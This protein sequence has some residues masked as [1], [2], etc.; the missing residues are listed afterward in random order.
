MF[1]KAKVKLMIVR[2]W[3]PTERIYCQD[4]RPELYRPVP[5]SAQLLASI[6]TALRTLT[7]PTITSAR[8][9]KRSELQ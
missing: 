6:S 7:F 2:V 9:L 4:G 1:T 5:T 8:L 3:A